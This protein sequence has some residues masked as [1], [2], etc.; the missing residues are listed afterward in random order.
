MVKKNP[1]GLKKPIKEKPFNRNYLRFI[2]LPQDREFFSSCFTLKEGAYH[3]RG[4]L[5]DKT[6]GRLKSLAKVIKENRGIL[7][8]APLILLGILAAG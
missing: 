2:E 1:R 6:R 5:D 7:K 4:E 8:I 3:P